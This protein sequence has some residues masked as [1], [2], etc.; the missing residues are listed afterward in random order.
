[1]TDADKIVELFYVASLGARYLELVEWRFELV[2]CN[3]DTTTQDALIADKKAEID[4][5]LAKKGESA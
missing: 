5:Y 2:R 1:M 3:M 4:R